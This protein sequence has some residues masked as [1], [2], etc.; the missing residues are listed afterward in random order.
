VI[1]AKTKKVKKKEKTQTA[2]T[3]LIQLLI[4]TYIQ[5]ELVP[6]NSL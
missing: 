5:S 4:R 2:F 6:L 1:D 3:A